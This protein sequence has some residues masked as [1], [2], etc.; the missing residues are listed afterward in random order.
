M[1]FPVSIR[2]RNALAQKCH[3]RRPEK[4]TIAPP[5]SLRT[6]SVHALHLQSLPYQPDNSALFSRL[7]ALPCPVFL[8][9]GRPGSSRGRYD[10]L[11]ADPIELIVRDSTE[12]DAR[13]LDA[14]LAAL[15]DALSR[16][17]PPVKNDHGLPFTGG[18]IGWLSYE[19]GLRWQH[20]QATDKPGLPI[21]GLCAGLY[22]WAIIADHE[23]EKTVLVVHPE[24]PGNTAARVLAQLQ[25]PA[26]PASP[27]RVGDFAS[28][29]D[30]AAYEDR[31][32]QTQRYISAGDCYQINLARCLEAGFSGDPWQAYQRLREATAAPYSAYLNWPDAEIISLSPERFIKIDE[33]RIVTEPIKG[34]ARR[35]ADPATDKSLAAALRDSAK[36]RAENLMIIDLLR[37]DLGRVCVPGSIHVDNMFELQTFNT[38]HHLVSTVSGKLR[39]GIAAL[40]ALAACFPGGSITGAPKRRAME[41]IEELEPVRRGLYCG[42]I[43]YLSSNGRL[44]SNIAIRSLQFIGDRVSCFGGGGIVADSRCAAE[45]A[46]SND[47]ISLIINTLKNIP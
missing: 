42:S 4:A 2:P 21:A 22:Q 13:S 19:A 14:E 18:A 37:N 35:D 23:T 47:K 20:V 3:Y 24:A 41:I 45:Y 44:D 46:E 40:A 11:T 12:I 30:G 26:T 5:I 1:M 25:Q 15:Q 32:E 8:D 7:R 29:L 36:D 39:P 9:S 28:D 27:L 43:F 31:F 10:I 38:V 16:Q 34:T 6:P 17:L 33:H